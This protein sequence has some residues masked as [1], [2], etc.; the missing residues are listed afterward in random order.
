MKFTV[1]AGG[2]L[3]LVLLACYFVAKGKQDESATPTTSQD[4]SASQ[5]YTDLGK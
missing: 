5:P 4:S 1:I 3:A 2:L